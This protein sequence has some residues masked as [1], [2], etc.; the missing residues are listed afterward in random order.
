MKF[1]IV[2]A[3]FLISSYVP[4]QQLYQMKAGHDSRV[5]SFENPNGKKGQGGKT[6]KTAKGN[7]FEWL[8]PGQTKVLLDIKEQGII[9]RIW[10]TLN[11]S[12]KLLRSLRLQM[13]WDGSNKAAVDVP[14]GDFF[15]SNLGRTTAF[16][17]ALFS[18]PEGRSFNCYVP[19]PFRKGARIIITNES[20]RD[21]TKL[22]YDVDYVLAKNLPADALYFHAYWTRQITSKPGD[23]FLV[24][25]K[26]N[27]KGRFLGM[28]VGLNTDSVYDR[29]WWGEGEVKMYIDG[30]NE[31]PTI[32][33][34]GAEDYVGTGWGMG[35]YNNMYQGALLADES[36]R[37][38]VFYR[39]HIP[40]PIWFQKD[41][42]VTLQQIGG[43]SKEIVKG[44]VNL[45]VKLQ[46]VTVDNNSGFVRLFDMANTPSI[47]DAN[48]PEGW[49]N[50]YRVDDYSAVS[51]LYLDKPGSNLPSLPLHGIRLI[52]VK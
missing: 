45:G 28:S 6:N 31:F 20:A 41:I 10:L 18:S 21:T 51:Y 4:G 14:L 50:F 2:I 37:R 26:V 36:N 47:N 32:N 13:F 52:N 35:V 3:S 15:V 48:F 11:Q 1:A 46:P 16:Q 34:T 30:D 39:W 38:F 19:M 12:P 22:F 23:D 25:P 42:K 33:G 24:L 7:A 8:Y 5:S 49:V 40:D 29:T 17:S 27:G 43:A 9:Q 44:K